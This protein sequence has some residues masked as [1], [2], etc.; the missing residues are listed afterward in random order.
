MFLCPKRRLL[1]SSHYSEIHFSLQWDLFLTIV[2]FISHYS[3]TTD[4][5]AVLA[6]RTGVLRTGAPVSVHTPAGLFKQAQTL[7][8]LNT[9]RV[10]GRNW[11]KSITF[12]PGKK[13]NIDKQWKRNKIWRHA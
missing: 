2:G 9:M 10:R 13:K 1:L 4:E 11:N 8:F 7:Y 5:A 6:E 3:E 12:T